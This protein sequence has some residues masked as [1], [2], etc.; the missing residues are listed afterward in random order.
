MNVTHNFTKGCI[1]QIGQSGTVLAFRKKQIP[2][3]FSLGL[4]FEFLNN[5]DDFPAVAFI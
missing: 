5:G 3:A 4:L 2:K 1:L